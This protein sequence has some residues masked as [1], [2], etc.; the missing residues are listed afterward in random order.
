MT[1]KKY[2]TNII[3]GLYLGYLSSATSVI[4]GITYKNKAYTDLDCGLVLGLEQ[5]RYLTKELI[6]T[7]GIRYYQGAKNIANTENHF[8]YAYNSTLEF[9]L[10]IKYI[11]LKKH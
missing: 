4:N 11:F 6:I 3:G 5:D 7:P 8:S 10:G 1:I 2:S 9:N